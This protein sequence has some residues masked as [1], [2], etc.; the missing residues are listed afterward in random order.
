[1]DVGAS[2]SFLLMKQSFRKAAEHILST[3][4]LQLRPGVSVTPGY[5]TEGANII[6]RLVYL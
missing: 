2:F 5:F 3:C 4:K 6:A 1:M